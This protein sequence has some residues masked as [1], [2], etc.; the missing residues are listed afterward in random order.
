MYGF[1]YDVIKKRYG[2]NVNM[3][4]TDTDSLILNIRTDDVYEDFRAMKE[5]FDFSSYP[6]NHICYD[7]SNKKKYW[8]SSN[9]KW[10]EK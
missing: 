5:Y 1:Y 4:Y 2:N 9:V 3:C 10:M 6:K 8:G 7:P